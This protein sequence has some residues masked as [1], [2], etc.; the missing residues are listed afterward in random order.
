MAIG[1]SL[2]AQSLSSLAGARSGGDAVP[3][4]IRGSIALGSGLRSG[5][6]L[7]ETA[8]KAAA[9]LEA[10]REAAAE[11]ARDAARAEA[12]LRVAEEESARAE[13]EG[14]SQAPV[15]TSQFGLSEGDAERSINAAR[16][17]GESGERTERGAFVDLAV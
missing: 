10:A 12:D 11:A 4:G 14:S 17:A 2:P 6:V 3:L 8:N 9:E 13:G 15:N 5:V 16:S 7:L 1:S